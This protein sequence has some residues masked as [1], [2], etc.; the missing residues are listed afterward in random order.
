MSWVCFSLPQLRNL[1]E[2]QARRP[3]ANAADFLFLSPTDY[4]PLMPV[5]A[6]A[7][8]SSSS[9]SSS[10]DSSSAQFR[11]FSQCSALPAFTLDLFN[12]Q[13]LQCHFFES[14]FAVPFDEAMAAR[15][16][17][18]SAAALSNSVGS[19]FST[20][21]PFLNLAAV[22]APAAQLLLRLPFALPFALRVDMFYRLI[23]RDRQAWENGERAELLQF[24]H[25]FGEHVTV[26]RDH[27]IT[28]AFRNL[29]PLRH[30]MKGRVRISFVNADGMPEA[31]IDGGGAFRVR[32]KCRVS[33]LVLCQLTRAPRSVLL[34]LVVLH[35][36][37]LFK[38]F[39]T[40]LTSEAFAPAVGLFR[41][42][43]QHLLFPNP[44]SGESSA[45]PQHH[46]EV[47]TRFLVSVV[48]LTCRV[49][50]HIPRVGHVGVCFVYALSTLSSWVEV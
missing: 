6:F 47:W 22:A 11:E 17:T 27:L 30:K 24:G 18:A 28:D 1:R 48:R 42:T 26:R 15:A 5:H 40:R 35:R 33:A 34:R 14:G 7:I 25:G 3:F 32:R 4:A 19:V 39:L 8:K 21:S 50:S 31:G 37:G 29:S 13:L 36:T 45:D 49:P 44:L 2:R 12:R 10:A 43:A 38:E 46:L 16:A 23:A 20:R 9:T 41:E